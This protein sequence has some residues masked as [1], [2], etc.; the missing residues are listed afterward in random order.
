MEFLI[1]VL[2]CF[3]ELF[4]SWLILGIITALLN[5]IC[6]DTDQA[7]AAY[8]LVNRQSK[9][10]RWYAKRRRVFRQA[11]RCKELRDRSI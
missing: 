7:E 4:Y 2:L 9:I 3:P 6:D 1:R 10:R 8:R 5:A 11:Q